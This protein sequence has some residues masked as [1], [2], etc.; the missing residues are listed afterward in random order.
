MRAVIIAVVLAIGLVGVPRAIEHYAP[1]PVAV[2][3]PADL[4][5]FDKTVPEVMKGEAKA[6]AAL[7]G[8]VQGMADRLA[9]DGERAKP[10][11]TWCASVIEMRVVAMD[12]AMHD[13]PKAE[14]PKKL[15]AAVGPEFSKVLGD[16]KL[17]QQLDKDT[18]KAVVDRLDALAYVLQT[19]K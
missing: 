15:G 5:G 2:K 14:W 12:L 8:V 9:S 18:R 16:D 13:Y 4:F 1:A 3:A 19:V 17:S 10:K 11:I 7:A 6:A